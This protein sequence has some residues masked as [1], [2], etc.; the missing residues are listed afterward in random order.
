MSRPTLRELVGS[1]AYGILVTYDDGLRAMVLKVGRDGTRWNFACRV[2]G[3][4]APR[5]THFYVGPWENRNLFKALSHAI[6]HLIHTGKP[7]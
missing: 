1:P 4:D 2:E 5:A 3:E 6:Q 7:P